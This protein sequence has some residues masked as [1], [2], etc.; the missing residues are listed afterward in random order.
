MAEERIRGAVLVVDD[1][2]NAR[3]G[4]QKLLEQEGFSVQTAADGAE[5]LERL[6]QHLADVVV[7]DLRMPTMD[8]LELLRRV[9]TTYEDLPVLVVTAFGAIE[10]AIEAMRAGAEDYLQKPVV[11]DELLIALDQALKHRGVR[12]E[13]RVLRGR[14]GDKLRPA[15]IV[16]ESPAM[17]VVFKTVAQVAPTRA[18]VLLTG[19]SGTGKELIAQAL[20]DGS[21]RRAGPFVKLHCAALAESLLESELFGHEKGSFTG[22]AGRREGR[23]KQADGGTLFLDEVGEIPPG[24]Q[25][26]LL[27]FLQERSFERV[28]SNETLKVDVRIIAATNRRL[29]QEVREGRFRE[30][31][32]YRL[33]VVAIEMP[34]L[35]LR[36]SDVL[37][38]AEHFLKKYAYENGKSIDGF[39][40]DALARL[41]EYSWPGNVREL[42]NVIERA[43]VLAEETRVGTGALPTSLSAS[44]HGGVPIPGSTFADIERHAIVSTL[45][46]VGWSTTRAARMLDISVRTIQYRLH[47]YGLA[48]HPVD[49]ALEKVSGE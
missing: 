12:E 8:G 7:T 33:N 2:L 4:L 40:P 36:P 45:E 38:L 5:A 37:L 30:D 28:G 20:H 43:V 47:Q 17:Q 19:E 15:N 46:A 25:V 34:P 32:F 3:R 42:E 49:K 18:S 35:R 1:E 16:G 11:L 13:V 23:F 31:L 22:A 27:R 29:E 6:G 44:V 41:Q 24:I 9:K 48:K 10:S 21:P 26:K 14:L 39:S